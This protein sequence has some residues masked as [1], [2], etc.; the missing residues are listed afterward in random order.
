M[1]I[2]LREYQHS[3]FPHFTFTY[4][5]CVFAGVKH[6]VNRTLAVMSSSFLRDVLYHSNNQNEACTVIFPEAKQKSV[7]LFL[8]ALYRGKISVVDESSFAQNKFQ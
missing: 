7:S 4:F 6:E 8:E 3:L 1:I 2:W 5:L